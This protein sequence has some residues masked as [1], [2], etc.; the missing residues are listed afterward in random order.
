MLSGARRQHFSA[1][2]RA[3]APRLARHAMDSGPGRQSAAWHAKIRPD[4]AVL[5]SQPRR[6]LASHANSRPRCPGQW[7][8]M[9]TPVR[10]SAGR[11]ACDIIPRPYRGISVGAWRSLVARIVRDDEVGGSNPLA[12]TS[13]TLFPCNVAASRHA[14][15][16][17]PG[18]WRSRPRWPGALDLLLAHLEQ[19][20]A[21]GEADRVDRLAAQRRALK[22]LPPRRSAAGAGR[23]CTGG[24]PVGGRRRPSPAIVRRAEPERDRSVDRGLDG[25]LGTR[26]LRGGSA[27][28]PRELVIRTRPPRRSRYSSLNQAAK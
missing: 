23:T 28:P 21:L 14:D 9:P 26:A 6:F 17:A 10:D 8:P 22:G 24:L 2:V 4:S 15:S 25:P 16:R 1:G 12:P 27:Q 19:Q 5:T 7:P 3:R 20:L 11:P 18:P 13:L